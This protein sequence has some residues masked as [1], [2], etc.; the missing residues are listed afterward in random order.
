[1][2]TAAK[3][4]LYYGG[5]VRPYADER[6]VEALL[7]EDGKVRY[8]G[9]L[10][11]AQAIAEAAMQN[12]EVQPAEVHAVD[13]QGCLLI[14]GL[15]DAHVH[16]WKVG[17]LRTTMLDLR[18]AASPEE[19]NRLVQERHAA[20]P[21]GAWLWGRGWNEA[22]LGLIPTR[23]Q[24]DALAPGRP[25][26]LTRTC[27]HIHAVNSLALERAGIDAT[28]P[29]PSG[30]EIQFDSGLLTETAY[31]LVF[32]AMPAP[33]QQDYETW[34]LAGLNY[35]KSLGFTSATDP[36]VDPPLYAAY[37]ALDAA[38]KLPIRVNLLYIWRPDGGSQTYPL[39][40]KHFSAMLR[41]DSVKFFTDGGLSG[42]TAAVSVPYKETGSQGVLRFE[43]ED[44]YQLAREAYLADFHI[45]AHAIG[46]TALTQLLGVYG[47]L[48]AE[49]PAGPRNRIEHFGLPSAAHLALA[50]QLKVIA[51]PQPVFLHELRLN[52]Q[53]Y[54]PDELSG[55]VFPLRAM[56]DAGLDVAFSSDGPVVKELRP[57]CGLKAAVAEAYVPGENVTLAQALRAYTW[58]GAVATGVQ[59][60]RGTLEPGLLADISLIER[61]LFDLPPDAWPALSVQAIL[62]SEHPQPPQFHSPQVTP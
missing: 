41:C 61:D 52:Y 15:T 49:F 28:T 30:G 45:A 13:L 14:P 25:V 27:A 54:I 2:T 57:L 20:L 34:V 16:V 17:Q 42:A 59:H 60:T 31:G 5:V 11:A 23:R 10:A 62:A 26:L 48:Q 4:V 39:P 51:V 50:R 22:K 35:L 21:E 47:R 36:A 12:A 19:F 24:L 1:M 29:A 6:T 53:R 55:Q 43:D 8:A 56:L 18:E 38:G 9:E 32:Q 3:Y 7:V 44:L 58:G 40:E 33:S 37:R 46:D